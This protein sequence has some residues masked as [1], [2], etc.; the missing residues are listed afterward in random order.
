MRKSR[1][2]LNNHSNYLIGKSLT[3]GETKAL[4]LFRTTANGKTLNEFLQITGH[5]EEMNWILELINLDYSFTENFI[6]Y[7]Y[8]Q[9]LL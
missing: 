3:Y 4:I 5:N 6:D 8:P 1:L 9:W 7:L 2:D